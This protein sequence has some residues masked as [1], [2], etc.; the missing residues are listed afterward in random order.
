M[1]GSIKGAF[2]VHV[3]GF[4]LKLMGMVAMSLFLTTFAYVCS[5]GRGERLG[6]NCTQ[7]KRWATE[8]GVQAAQ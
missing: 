5:Y 8:S 1:S 7:H 6:F 2:E 4:Q 3:Q